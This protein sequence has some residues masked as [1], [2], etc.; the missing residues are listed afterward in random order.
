MSTTLLSPIELDLEKSELVFAPERPEP[1]YWVGCPSVTY[2]NGRFLLTYRE[3]RPRDLEFERGWRCAVAESTDG[4]N[5][6][7]VWSVRK[8]ELGT[9]SME[10][11]SIARPVPGGDYFLY[12]SYVDPADNRWRIDVVT[13]PDVSQFDV[14][15][16]RPVLTADSTKSAGIKDPYTML[17]GG[18]VLMYTV[19]S[20][21]GEFGE[22]AFATA[23]I[24]NTDATTHATGLA[25]SQDGLRFDYLGEVLPTGD[26]WDSHESRLSCVVPTGNGFL[27][28]YDGSASYHENYE[29]RCGLAVSFDLRNWTKTTPYGPRYVAPHASGSIRYVDIAVVDGEWYVY[30]E[31]TRADG[32]HELRLLRVPGA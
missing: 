28:F 2:D 19:T 27:G 14:S 7:D 12:L 6:T 13:A 18:A 21:P 10:R 25:I 22:E 24:H 29:E 9:D 11:F 5:F 17:V 26:G 4:V 8:D 3:R 31:M 32:A 20:R 16:R 15:T 1:G 30:F 23:D